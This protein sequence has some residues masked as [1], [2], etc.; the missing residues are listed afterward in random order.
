MDK[1]DC[2]LKTKTDLDL[3]VNFLKS[4]Y[5]SSSSNLKLVLTLSL[6]NDSHHQILKPIEAI[7]NKNSHSL[8]KLGQQQPQQGS[9]KAVQINDLLNSVL[10]D[11]LTD[12]NDSSLYSYI[13][14]LF[15]LLL[16]ASRYGL[17]ES[18]L[19]EIIRIFTDNYLIPTSTSA[20]LMSYFTSLAWYSIK[21]YS[22]LFQSQSEFLVYSSE[23]SQLM[24]RLKSSLNGKLN[25][26]EDSLRLKLNTILYKYF[27]NG[28]DK[29]NY[30]PVKAQFSLAYFSQRAY[31]ELPKHYLSIETSE[32]S[33]F[34]GALF[35][36]L[37]FFTLSQK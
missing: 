36:F 23:N 8:L 2:I 12:E 17:K 27:Q 1:L 30:S 34:L 29:A 32:F 31:H 22:K 33:F 7:L 13:V 37:I 16:S 11:D 5:S 26:E 6:T 18:E 4:I 21:Y 19:I 20:K 9:S 14:D 25:D 28:L 10:F 3:L 35:F 15:L 24:F